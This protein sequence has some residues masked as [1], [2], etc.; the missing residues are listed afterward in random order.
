MNERGCAARARRARARA[1]R[2]ASGPGP[3]RPP[4]LLLG[5][6]RRAR[7]AR[8]SST[9]AC[10]VAVAVVALA[11]LGARADRARARTVR[12]TPRSPTAIARD[13]PVD[14]LGRAR[15]RSA[16]RPLRHRRV[17]AGA[18]RAV[19]PHVVRRSRPATTRSGC[20]CSR[21]AIA[22]CSRGGSG[23]LH[24]T[25]FDGRARWRHAV[26]AARPVAGARARA[27]TRRAARRQRPPRR[28]AAR[29]RAARRRRHA[30]CSPGSCSATPAPFPTT[31]WPRTATPGLSHLLAV[32]GENVAFTLALF[33]PLLRRLRARAAHGRRDRDR[34]AVRDD[35]AL[36]AVGAP[37][38]GVGDRRVGLVVRRAP[39]VERARAGARGH[40]AARCSIRSC[41]T[42]SRSGCRAARAR[43]SRLLSGPLRARLPGPDVVARPAR[44]VARRAGRAS[45]RCCS[46]RSE[47][48]RSSRRSRTCS[49]RRRPRRSACTGCSRAPSAD[50]CRRSRRCC[51]SRRRVLIAWV[52]AVA[53]AG[54][55]VGIDLDRRDGV[56]P[57]RDRAARPPRCCVRRRRRPAVRS[58]ASAAV[59]CRLVAPFPTIR[60]GDRTLRRAHARARDGD[61]QPH[62]R[63]VLRPGRDVE[64][65]RV[66]APGRGADR[67]TA[68]T[69]STSA[70]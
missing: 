57:A 60:I 38:V 34:A 54:A 24:P 14:A 59:P 67:P 3:R 25:R 62:A 35:D 26:G 20:A 17:R 51:S 39:R 63:L 32:S 13:A 40:R 22:S 56:V 58:V 36:R 33:G 47:R 16:E 52:T 50:S 65:R 1:S 42:R 2:P 10:A 12:C 7:P 18:G 43:A 61:P 64:L 21:P 15:R 53:R 23:P 66:P 11:L 5:R 4:A 48:C 30:R 45:R 28:R 27:R 6:H 29:H 9:A 31:S 46:R 37:R 44:R 19:A 8:G 70:A 41:C 69:C 55:A 68:P 49:R